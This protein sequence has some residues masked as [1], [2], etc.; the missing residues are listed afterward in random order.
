MRRPGA[1]YSACMLPS[2]TVTRLVRQASTPCISTARPLTQIA[3][4]P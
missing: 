1:A 2:R 4:T 3:R